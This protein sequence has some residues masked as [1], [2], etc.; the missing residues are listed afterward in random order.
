VRRHIGDRESEKIVNRDVRS[1]KTPKT[2]SSEIT[3]L[4]FGHPKNTE[5][6]RTQKIC[7]AEITFILVRINYE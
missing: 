5:P 4:K 3:E 2:G 1:C 7:E 6:Y